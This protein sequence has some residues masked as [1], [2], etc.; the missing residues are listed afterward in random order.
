MAT[1]IV[2]KI[3]P[4]ELYIINN[5]EKATYSVFWQLM[6]EHIYD[7]MEHGMNLLAEFRCAQT[8]RLSLRLLTSQLSI[9]YKHLIYYLKQ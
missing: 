5:K 4:C 6:L 3:L 1:Q 9:R 8:P 2:N 7:K